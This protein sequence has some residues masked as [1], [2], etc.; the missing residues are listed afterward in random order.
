MIESKLEDRGYLAYEFQSQSK[1]EI[2][3]GTQGRD[4]KQKPRGNTL[5]IGL[6]PVTYSAVSHTIPDHLPRLALATLG[7]SDGDISSTDVPIPR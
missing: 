6:F 4:L 5:L 3:V 1:R 2:R 7:Q